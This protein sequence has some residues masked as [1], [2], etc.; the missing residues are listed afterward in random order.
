V[1]RKRRTSIVQGSSST[2]SIPLQVN[3]SK[4]PTSDGLG[5]EILLVD[6]EGDSDIEDV[7]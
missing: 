1:L 5:A 7:A 6:L 4:P 3:P 2:Q